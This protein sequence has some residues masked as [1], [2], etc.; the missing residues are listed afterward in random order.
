MKNWVRNEQKTVWYSVTYENGVSATVEQNHSGFFYVIRAPKTT[1]LQ[2]A[3]SWPFE[4]PQEAME[5]CDRYVQ[6]GGEF[7]KM[8]QP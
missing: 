5:S 3:Q 8:V 7:P 6:S 1:V 2:S 4:T